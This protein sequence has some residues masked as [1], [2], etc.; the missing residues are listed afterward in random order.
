MSPYLCL[1]SEP[2][3]QQGEDNAPDVQHAIDLGKQGREGEVKVTLSPLTLGRT[4]ETLLWSKILFSCFH[5]QPLRI[6]STNL[7]P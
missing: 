5:P 7:L 3:Q 2:R 1:S 6:L 4:V